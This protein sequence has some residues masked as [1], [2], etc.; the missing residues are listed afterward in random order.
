VVAETGL[1]PF[2]NDRVRRRI[3]NPPAQ[4]AI[5]D[6]AGAVET[7]EI[8]V[9]PVTLVTAEALKSSHNTIK[10]DAQALNKPSK[11]ELLRD[12]QKIA[13]AAGAAIA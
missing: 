2:N 6:V 8:P 3:P 13:S 4:F 1:F 11:E 7:V 12:V 10:Q 5:P 9:T